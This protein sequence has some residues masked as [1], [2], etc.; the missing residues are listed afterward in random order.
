MSAV[1]TRAQPGHSTAPWQPRPPPDACTAS[2]APV[3]D[4]PRL[5]PGRRLPRPCRS[6]PG[7]G[8][9][10]ALGSCRAEVTV[11]A[12]GRKA[13][14]GLASRGFSRPRGHH[15][16][17][18]TSGFDRPRPHG[19]ALGQGTWPRGVTHKAAFLAGLARATISSWRA[20][21]S[22]GTESRWN[23]PLGV[24]AG[25]PRASTGVLRPWAA[26]GPLCSGVNVL[27]SS[28]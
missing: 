21:G 4:F 11:A 6:A 10:G 19:V 2:R 3:H 5:T 8:R 15:A 24:V 27:P 18:L 23:Q 22:L 1:G 9:G 7:R 20:R 25:R 12:C 14:P 17:T 28:F 13:S 26:P 16:S